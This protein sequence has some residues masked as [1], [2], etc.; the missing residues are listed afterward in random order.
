M[1]PASITLGHGT[2]ASAP[3]GL[4][5]GLK[6]VERSGRMERLASRAKGGNRALAGSPVESHLRWGCKATFNWARHAGKRQLMTPGGRFMPE[7]DKSF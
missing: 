2:S 7:N 6:T 4:S 5:S 1:P 3:F